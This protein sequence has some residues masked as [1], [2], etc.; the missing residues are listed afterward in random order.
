LDLRLQDRDRFSVKS[1]RCVRERALTELKERSH[2]P[3]IDAECAMTLE[4]LSALF[5]AID[6]MRRF[7]QCQHVFNREL[8]ALELRVILAG[9]P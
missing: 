8:G 9:R 1:R 3:S 6:T 5:G 4:K 2:G 7:I